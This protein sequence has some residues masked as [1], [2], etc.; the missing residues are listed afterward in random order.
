MGA[1]AQPAVRP[2]P[3][4][5]SRGRRR[6]EAILDVAEEVIAEVGYD[7][8][9]TNLIAARARISPGSLY[10]YFANKPAIVEALAQRYVTELATTHGNVFAPD[11]VQLPVPQLVERVVEPLI[12]FN[13]AHPAA[14]TLL[15][16]VDLSPELARATKELHAALC[17][18]VETLL[19][20]LAPSKTK[21]DRH[22]A[23][24]T[25]ISIFCS[26]LPAIAA[27]DPRQRP[28]I[29]RELKAALTA[30]WATMTRQRGPRS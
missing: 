20:A 12:A 18:Q 24:T 5:Q 27:A 4:R 16:G 2:E 19:G 25:S 7:A 10:Q 30:Y 6:I 8:T 17:D 13:L 9:T 26:V 15:A 21:A 11:L 23:A 14:K 3:N 29:I 28:R 22:L 1:V